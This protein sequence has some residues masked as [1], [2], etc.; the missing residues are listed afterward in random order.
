MDPFKKY[1]CHYCGVVMDLSSENPTRI[2]SYF[3]HEKCV[4]V[5]FDRR[6]EENKKQTE[7]GGK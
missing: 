2:G 4:K 5:E 6:T 1:V 7:E 3:W